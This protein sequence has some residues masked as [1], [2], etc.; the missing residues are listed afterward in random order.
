MSLGDISW[1]QIFED[2][3]LQELIRTALAENYDLRI[4]VARILA[5]RARL[6]ITRSEQFP[7]I[8]AN[9]RAI[10]NRTEGDSPPATAK[11]TLAPVGSMDLS[12]E[13]DLW[14]RLRRA[15]EAARADLLASE[16]A[17]QTVVTTLVSD[18]ATAYF[19]LRELDLELEIAHRTLDS[20]Q[21]ALRLV[22]ARADGGVA[23]LIDVRQAETLLYAAAVVIPDTER[24]I[25]QRE[26]LISL[27]VGRNPTAVPRGRSLLQQL[28]L[29]AVPSGLPSALLERRPDIRQTEQ[30][31]L[32]AN[33]RIGVAKA[34]FF[35]Q[36]VLTGSAG[37]G[38]TGVNGAFFGP[39]GLFAVGP[40]LTLPIF[41]AGRIRAGVESAEAGQQEALLRY[42]QSIQQAF[43]EVSDALV[44]HRRRQEFRV[45]QEALT[46]AWQ[47]A[48]R[49]SRRRYEGGVT[50]FLEVLDTER[51]LFDSELDLAQAQLAER[52][53]VVQLYKALGGGW[54]P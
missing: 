36:V 42:L 8:D 21:A 43:R 28:A 53:A 2:E 19:Q 54:Q 33:A 7:T 22:Q 10:Y 38:A 48:S 25:E 30:Q 5:A 20:R 4:A 23:S 39:Q 34:L 9:G 16:E 52:L 40:S 45:Q 26:N 13:I 17:R 50:S 46:K 41:N 3:Q 24:R 15:T 14:G 47:D 18:V 27:I 1:W 44:E 37:I 11:E 51:E 35:P 49:L 12:F 6:T 31:L 32:S 29:P